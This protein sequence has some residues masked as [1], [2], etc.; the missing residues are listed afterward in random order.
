V[1]WSPEMMLE[2]SLHTVALLVASWSR[3]QPSWLTY[4]RTVIINEQHH[5]SGKSRIKIADTLY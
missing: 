5:L 1:N 4:N 2:V 3:R